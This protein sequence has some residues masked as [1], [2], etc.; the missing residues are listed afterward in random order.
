VRV[1]VPDDREIVIN[2]EVLGEAAVPAGE[3]DDFVIRKAD[4]Y[5][6]YH[7]AV[8]VD[9][10]TMGVTHVLRAQ[11]HHKNTAKHMLIQDALG[12]RRPVYGH[13]PIM[14]NPDGSKMSKRDKDKALRKTV[15]EQGWTA[16]PPKT[17]DP[18]AFNAWLADQ[19]RQLEFEPS[20]ALA[21]A[22][23][24]QLPEINIEDFRR[25]GYLPEVLCNFLALNGGSPA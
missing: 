22:L 11:E 12:F 18:D 13:M 5:P 14:C 15:K 25:S 1:K 9:D 6:T 19:D 16:P 23:G 3:I 17:I 24:I 2:D 7:F 8:V 21:D 20:R 10:E 4:G